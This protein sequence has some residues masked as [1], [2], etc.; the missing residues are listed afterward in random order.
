MRFW[1]YLP[2]CVL[3][4]LLAYPLVPLA[5]LLSDAEGRLPRPLRWLETHDALGWVGPMTEQ[6]TIRTTERFGRRAG[7]V[8][9]LWRNKAYTLRWWLRARITDDMPRSQSGE[10]IPARWGFSMWRGSIGPYWEIQPRIGLGWVHLYLRIGWKMKPLLDG[11]GPYGLA[12]GIFTGVS[13]R[14][15]DWDDYAVKT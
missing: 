1:L 3:G 5:V 15:D 9:Y 12:A 7:L 2:I 8:H 6:A 14:S 11:P 13:V 10:A 4:W